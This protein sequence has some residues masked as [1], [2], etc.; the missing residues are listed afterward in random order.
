MSKHKW[1]DVIIAWANGAE[2]EF[3]SNSHGWIPCPNPCWNLDPE[4]QYRIKPN[5][6]QHLFDAIKEGMTI[7]YKSRDGNW[8]DCLDESLFIP[9]MEYRIK[10]NKHQHLIDAHK[11]GKTIQYKLDDGQWY[12][13]INDHPLFYDDIEYRI[14]HKYQDVI[15]AYL[16]GETIQYYCWDWKGW[17]WYDCD[18]GKNLTIFDSGHEYRIKPVPEYQKQIDNILE[19]FDFERVHKVMKYLDWQWCRN[20]EYSVP[21]LHELKPYAKK[22][23]DQVSKE[24]V[25]NHLDEYG[26]ECGGFVA[27]AYKDEKNPDNVLLMLRFSLASWYNYE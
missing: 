23:L 21:E 12:D 22:L 15:G 7:Q 18:R 24:V 3:K 4:S 11:Q 20:G 9:T 10:P 14:K 17:A 26:L 8:Y 1:A 16:R 13:I 19:N 6:Y 25:I 2:I 27:Q 5:K